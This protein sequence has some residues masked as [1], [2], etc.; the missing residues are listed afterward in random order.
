MIKFRAELAI[1]GV[2]LSLAARA[3]TG[4]SDPVISAAVERETRAVTPRAIAW[5]RDIH[6]HPELGYEESRT[7]GLVAQ[8][9]RSLGSGNCIG[10]RCD[11]DGELHTDNS[12]RHE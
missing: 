6:E 2:L 5:R 8:H 7:A 4:N 11:G 12:A 3:E 1:I 9:L 10:S